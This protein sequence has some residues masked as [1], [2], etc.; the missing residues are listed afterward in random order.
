[1]KELA[2]VTER[3]RALR[4][5]RAAWT[6]VGV[7]LVVAATVGIVAA[8]RG[9]DSKK[10]TPLAPDETTVS[11][12]PTTV[13]PLLTTDLPV[14]TIPV[15]SVVE[16]PMTAPATTPV[17]ATSVVPATT[18]ASSTT[19]V[20]TTTAVAETTT[21]VPVIT[22]PIVAITANGAAVIV[23]LDGTQTLLRE[24]TDPDDPPPSEGESSFI[25]SIAITGDG[26]VAFVGDCCEPVVGYVTRFALPDTSHSEGTFGH[27]PTV[28]PDNAKVAIGQLQAIAVVDLDLV[29]IARS[30]EDFLGDGTENGFVWLDNDR[31]V[32][33]SASPADAARLEV[34]TIA[35]DNTL[36]PGAVSDLPS[37]D[38]YSVRTAGIG[39][40]LIYLTGMAPATLTA[41]DSTTLQPVPASNVSLPSEALSAWMQDGQLRWVDT[42]RHLHIGDVVVPGEYI[43]VH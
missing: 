35:A 39:P 20:P 31:F 15:T 13:L 42:D 38:S 6:G 8:T 22:R 7:V 9:D 14:T 21:T 28:S 18:V 40:G 16:V 1:M 37:P 30:T 2:D 11:V 24:G 32:V 3:A 41:I 43:W 5:R 36:Q 29:E 27:N 34:M 26:S 33:L 25:D 17:I 19:E 23:A 12:V 4:R 10:I